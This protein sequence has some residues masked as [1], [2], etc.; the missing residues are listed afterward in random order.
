[1]SILTSVLLVLK[2][3]PDP[4]LPITT[5]QSTVLPRLCLYHYTHNMDLHSGYMYTHTHM[6]A[7]AHTGTWAH[8]HTHGHTHTHTHTGTHTHTHTQAHIHTHTHTGTHTHTHGHTHTHTGT[9]TDCT[10]IILMVYF[11][12][13]IYIL[14]VR[15]YIIVV[16][17][18]K[19]N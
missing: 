1:M 15:M 3:S 8:T 7:H 9:H 6:G 19:K 18:L 10:G 16:P 11:L 12:S 5:F 13:F 17:F 14:C 2:E 4:S